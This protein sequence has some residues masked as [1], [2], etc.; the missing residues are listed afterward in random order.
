MIANGNSLSQGASNSGG[1]GN[2]MEGL[3]WAYV[4]A[5]VPPER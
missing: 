4:R 1:D 3:L 5:V 2:E